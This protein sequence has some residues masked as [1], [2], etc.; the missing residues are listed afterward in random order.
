[1][2][3]THSEWCRQGA[4]E[5]LQENCPQMFTAQWWEHEALDAENVKANVIITEWLIDGTKT[6]ECK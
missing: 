6:C 2:E 4:L 3:A 1:M 5:A